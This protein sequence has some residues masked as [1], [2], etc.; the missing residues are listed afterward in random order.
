MNFSH[1]PITSHYFGNQG[2]GQTSDEG[3][4]AMKRPK[5]KCTKDRRNSIYQYFP[6]DKKLNTTIR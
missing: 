1:V 5:R 4:D 2:S 6:R 3:D